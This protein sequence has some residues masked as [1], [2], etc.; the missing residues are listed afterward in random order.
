MQNE[1]KVL[2]KGNECGDSSLLK[3]KCVELRFFLPIEF[4]CML[5]TDRQ[6]AL[7]IIT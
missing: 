1:G 3:R 4:H 6:W 2:C 5:A 7:Y